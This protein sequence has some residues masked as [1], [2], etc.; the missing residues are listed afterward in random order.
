MIPEEDL[1]PAWL[2]DY[3]DIEADIGRM[4][5]LA[6]KLDAEV[7]GNYV[8]HLDLV[9]AAMTTP[10]PQPRADFPELVSF[11]QAHNDAQQ[12]T[13][14]NA[15]VYRD[16]T[17]GFAYA[18]QKVSRHYRGSDAFAA[19]RAADVR[20]ALDETAV[21]RVPGPGAPD[22]SGSFPTPTPPDTAGNV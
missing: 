4:E 22:T 16:A 18:A 7:R 1:P 2:R 14:V 13:S 3:G 10:L 19:A 6:A 5:E 15:H 17:G 20:D 12:L 21:A 11:M 9:D 8:P